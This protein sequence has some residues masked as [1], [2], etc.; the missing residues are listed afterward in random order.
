MKKLRTLLVKFDNNL[1]SW[2]A[3]AFRG[4]VIE[5]VGRENLLFHQHLG[6]NQFLYRYP[7]IQYKS[8]HKQPAIFCIGDGVDEIHK[9]FNKS[10]WIIQ[11][12]DKKVDL[13]IDDLRLNS[14]NLNVW[15]KSFNFT[16]NRWLALNEI[17]FAKYKAISDE[18]EK[19]EFLEKILI[20]NILSFAKG[21][22]WQIEKEVK[23]RIIKIV[24]TRNLKYKDT[25]LMSFD[26]DFTSNVFLPNYIGLG[27]GV[28]HG[29]GV[30]KMKRDSIKQ[31]QSAQ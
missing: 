17:N 12:K 3:S 13:T 16:L 15:D 25:H 4:A 8:I 10:N 27:K 2:E 6:E 19:I 30:V 26:V 1:N 29:Y 24:K 31:N 11:L 18:F 5:K 21:I 20:G 22:D 7:M 28:S 23:A 9:L 14:F